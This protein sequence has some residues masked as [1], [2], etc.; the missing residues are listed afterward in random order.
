MAKHSSHIHELA[1]RGAEVRFRELLDEIK[2][3]TVAFPRL[4]DSFDKDELPVNFILRK[5]RDRASKR[6]MASGKRGWSAAQRKA[7]KRKGPG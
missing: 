7:A 2:L 3:L 5:G 4:W 6:P 1:Q